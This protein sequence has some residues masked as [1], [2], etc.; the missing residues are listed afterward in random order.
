MVFMCEDFHPD[1]EQ[2]ESDN[3][4]ARQQGP[5]LVGGFTSQSFNTRGGG[6]TTRE[7]VGQ[8]TEIGR[9]EE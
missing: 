5:G 3:C 2:L 7:S 8:K 9:E 4:L 6:T 1:T